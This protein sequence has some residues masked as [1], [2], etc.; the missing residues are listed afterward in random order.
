MT[1][2]TSPPP[3]TRTEHQLRH[4][5]FFCVCS[6]LSLYVEPLNRGF[7][8]VPAAPT[9][10]TALTHWSQRAGSLV[11]LLNSFVRVHHFIR[12]LAV[13]SK[14]HEQLREKRSPLWSRQLA[15]L[16]RWS[17]AP[18]GGPSSACCARW[19]PDTWWAR[20]TRRGTTPAPRRAAAHLRTSLGG[21]R[22]GHE[23]LSIFFASLSS[24]VWCTICT[25][26]WKGSC[27]GHDERNEP[28][29]F[30]SILNHIQHVENLNSE[31]E[32]V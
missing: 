32:S 20:R 14:G 2:P 22:H 3:N 12:Q 7:I 6:E 27:Y 4:Q 26:T 11:F 16:T 28:C 21:Q 29:L 31:K 19:W 17:P 24:V 30:V 9:A 1:D 18:A 23:D 13:V 10:P 15:P 25:I 5:S 8:I